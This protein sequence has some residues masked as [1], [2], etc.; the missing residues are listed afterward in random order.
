MHPGGSDARVTVSFFEGVKNE[1]LS[2]TGIAV[3]AFLPASE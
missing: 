2:D 3:V 1:W